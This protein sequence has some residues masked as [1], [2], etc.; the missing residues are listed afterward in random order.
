MLGKFGSNVGLYNYF[1]FQ[2]VAER[3]QDEK[4]LLNTFSC[5]GVKLHTLIGSE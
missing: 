3:L 5:V 4:N 2:D 1:L